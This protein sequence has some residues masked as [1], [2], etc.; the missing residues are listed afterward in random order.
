MRSVIPKRTFTIARKTQA[1][2]I[3]YTDE[4]DFT[5]ITAIR[6]YRDAFSGA[7]RPLRLTEVNFPLLVE[8]Y[9]HRL[10]YNNAGHVSF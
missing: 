9:N 4:D 7:F 8:F 3:H 2:G 5:G 6:L 1:N 10:D